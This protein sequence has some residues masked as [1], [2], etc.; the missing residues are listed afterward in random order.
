MCCK[1]V[2]LSCLCDT[3]S[4]YIH[5]PPESCSPVLE[6]VVHQETGYAEVQYHTEYLPE[7]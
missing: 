6:Q 2:S 1:S 4:M 5:L 7:K 3:L